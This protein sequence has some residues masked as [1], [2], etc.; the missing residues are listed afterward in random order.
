MPQQTPVGK[1]RRPSDRVKDVSVA[2]TVRLLDC[3]TDGSLWVHPSA[4]I[5]I[6]PV[7]GN[8]STTIQNTDVG[9]VAMT[10]SR[11]VCLVVVDGGW[12]N[13]GVRPIRYVSP[14]WVRYTY[15][16]FIHPPISVVNE[17]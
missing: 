2:R 5:N 1:I 15:Q 7:S 13:L 6:L 3:R 12:L 11:S 17:T 10:V 4:V 16:E 9:V 14:E 8:I